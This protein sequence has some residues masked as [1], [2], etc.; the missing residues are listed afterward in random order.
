MPSAAILFVGETAE[1][2]RVARVSERLGGAA[3]E[4]HDGLLVLPKLAATPPGFP[5]RAGVARKR[6]LA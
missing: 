4:E 3:P 1:I 6:P 2:E 5:R